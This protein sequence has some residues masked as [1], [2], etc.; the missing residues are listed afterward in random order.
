MEPF[1]SILGIAD[2]LRSG[3]SV[4]PLS[5]VLLGLKHRFHIEIVFRLQDHKII[6]RML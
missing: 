4:S 2:F 5:Y 3:Y 1:G 6:S